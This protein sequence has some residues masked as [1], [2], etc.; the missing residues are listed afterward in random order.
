MSATNHTTNYN[1]PQFLGTDKPTWLTDVNNAMSAI[2]TQ[3]KANADSATG[4]DTKATT[5][6]NAIGTLANLQTTAKTDLV[7]AVNEVNTNVGTAQ[8]TAN[9]AIGSANATATA[10]NTFEQKFNLS[11]ISQGTSTNYTTTGTVN[12]GMTLA[13]NSDGSIFKA[14]GF[15]EI[16]KNSSC[17]VQSVAGLTGYYGID[18]G[19]VLTTSPSEAYII[20]ASGLEI[21]I[22]GDNGANKWINPKDMAVGTNGHIYIGIKRS[23]SKTSADSS[24]NI[25]YTYPPCIYFNGTF[26]DTPSP[27]N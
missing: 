10:L 19:L 27:D 11:D 4:A 12:N 25:N 20:K 22:N 21:Q 8:N 5:A 1:L 7:S 24:Y 26:G 23:S 2:D 14:Y 15:F 3:M 17:T 16:A 13:Q 6:T 18:T 9:T